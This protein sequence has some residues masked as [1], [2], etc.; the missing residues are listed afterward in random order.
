MCLDGLGWEDHALSINRQIQG[1]PLRL[2]AEHYAVDN[3]TITLLI[4]LLLEGNLDLALMISSRSADQGM[5]SADCRRLWPVKVA[6]KLGYRAGQTDMVCIP[7]SRVYNVEATGV[8]CPS[9]NMTQNL[10]HI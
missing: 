5:L 3:R 8:A 4:V 7:V 6:S 9:Q 2:P 1:Y 10:C